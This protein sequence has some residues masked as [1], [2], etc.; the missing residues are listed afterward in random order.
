MLLEE[1]LA[2]LEARVETLEWGGQPCSEPPRAAARPRG[3]APPP[4]V[5]PFRAA[6]APRPRPAREPRDRVDLEEL[7]GGRALAWLGAIAVLAGLGFL[8]TV[9]ISRGWLGEGART[10]LAGAG[11][12][13]LLA[14]GIRLHERCGRTEASLAAA[15]AGLA[16]CFATLVVAAEVYGLLAPLPALALALLTGAG[17]TAL[18][19]RWRAP[20][21]AWL[22]L[23]GAL[24]SPAALGALSTPGSLGFLAVAYAA[25]VGVLLWQR[26]D[27]LAFAAFAVATPQW[28]WLL[29]EHHRPLAVITLVLF[30]A[31]TVAA[32][33]GCELGNATPRLRPAAIALLVVNALVLDAA[34]WALLSATAWLVAVAL[35]HVA[36]GLAGL[37]TR[38]GW[39]ELALVTLGLG[40][41]LGDVAFAAL[42]S[43]LPL[44]LGWA[45]GAVGF[46]GLARRA[47]RTRADELFATSGLG[48][49]LLAALAHALVLDA[50]FGVGGGDVEAIVAVA[51]VA[52]GAGVS[53]RLAGGRLALPL[54]AAALATVAYLS[55]LALS[56]VALTGV[57]AAE[58]VA[59]ALLAGREN[60]RVAAAGA[61][62]FASLAGLHAGLVVAAPADA[63]LH[64][65]AAPFA[66]AGA[67]AAATVALAAASRAP[68]ALPHGARALQL[69]AVVSALYLAST[70]LVTAFGGLGGQALVSVLWALTGVGVLVAGL[71]LD[72]ADLRRGALVLLALTAGKVFVYDLASLTSL[73]RVA[74]LTGLG[75]L[76]L[77]GAYAWARLRPR[78]LP[79]LR[80]VP[81]ALR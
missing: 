25:T 44:V 56:G 55:I 30:G 51:T 37:R 2:A 21:I 43:G 1:R 70:E 40:V 58:A 68:H 11:S 19:L 42:T 36:V 34:G 64:G 6:P 53:A 72:R 74:S 28:V 61:A 27:G 46:A 12:L 76:L 39:R 10:V 41:V 38:R 65:L 26:W 75:L 78:A 66:A 52:A 67:L 3:A 14:A 18:A 59:L 54:N 32:A 7:L 17:G 73:Y 20:G 35:V 69:G 22:G 9:A 24:A 77:A 15:A 45:A 79:D 57:F 71:R 62:A 48:A 4:S 80:G 31:L 8:L 5:R 49:H 33:V 81:E 29:A 23:L 47:A 50:R 16:G 13:A 63:L 60:D